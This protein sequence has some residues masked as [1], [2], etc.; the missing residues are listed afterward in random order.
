LDVA[1]RVVGIGQVLQGW[2]NHVPICIGA[3]ATIRLSV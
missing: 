1:N 3:S 2:S